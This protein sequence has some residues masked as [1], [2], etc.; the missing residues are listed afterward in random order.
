MAAKGIT[1]SRKT[2]WEIKN[3]P[4][5]G[6]SAVKQL[7]TSYRDRPFDCNNIFSALLTNGGLGEGIGKGIKKNDTYVL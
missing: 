1:T 4:K 7:N 5:Y 2:N 3:S 6:W